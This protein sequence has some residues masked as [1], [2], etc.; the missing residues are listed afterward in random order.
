MY[1]LGPFL[2]ISEKNSHSLCISAPQDGFDYG[3]TSAIKY[4]G[5]GSTNIMGM[6]QTEPMDRQLTNNAVSNQSSNWSTRGSYARQVYYY[7]N[8]NMRVNFL[9]LVVPEINLQVMQRKIFHV[10][11]VMALTLSL[12]LFASFV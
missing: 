2:S 1:F 9:S 8:H 6:S 12:D 7:S 5:S 4:M 3:R 10:M 11:Q